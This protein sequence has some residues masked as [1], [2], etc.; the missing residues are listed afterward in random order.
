[1]HGLGTIIALNN[2]TAKPNRGANVDI[3]VPKRKVNIAKEIVE[4]MLA[5]NEEGSHD[6]FEGVLN[7]ERVA[8]LRLLLT[9]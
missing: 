4:Q 6:T 9:R 8:A 7:P 3:N 1:M 2:S 5:E